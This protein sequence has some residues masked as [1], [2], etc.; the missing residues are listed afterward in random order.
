MRVGATNEARRVE[1]VQ[2]QLKKIPAGSRLLDAGAGE[3]RFKAS[4]GHLR[5]VSQDFAQYDGK[6][7]N[8]G[9]QTGK[10]DQTR[11]DIVGDITAI[12]EP[13]DSFDAVLCVEVLE[14]LPDPVLALAEFSRLLRPNGALILTAPF[15]SLTHFAPFH[16][17]TGFNRYFYEHHLPKL[18]FKITEILG[19]GDFF[20]YIAQEIRRISVVASA[21]TGRTPNLLEKG[22]MRIVLHM[23]QRFAE[24]D[25]GSSELL[26]F[27]Y[28]VRAMREATNA[29]AIS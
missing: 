28:H 2:E 5:Y 16:F 22:A 29:P 19:N 23:L 20:H 25:R 24:A 15:C 26:N 8:K 3:L 9:L 4:C 11:V 7:D 6:G 21:Y 12:P 17:Q 13:S 18:G 10:W 1:W 27:G 14:H